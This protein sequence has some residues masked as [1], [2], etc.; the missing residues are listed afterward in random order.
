YCDCRVDKFGFADGWNYNE[1]WIDVIVVLDTSEA[2]GS[3]A[4]EDTAAL[5]ESLISD[6]ADDL[7]ITNTYLP[8][9]TRVG[10]LYNLNMTKADKVHGKVA[11]KK[12]VKEM[13]I[14]AGFVAAL[15]MFDDGLNAKP[16][17]ANTRQV[18]YYMT[19]SD[20]LKEGEAEMQGLK[21]LASPG[22]YF[23]SENYML[24]LQ[25]FCKANCFCPHGRLAYGGS[26]PAI[27]ASGGCY[28]ASTSGIPFNNAKSTCSNEGGLLA[29]I[30]DDQK[31]Q[32]VNKLSVMAH[33]KSD[34]FWIGYEKSDAGAWQWEDNSDD[35][36]TNWG[37]DEP[38]TNAVA[39]CGY[40]DSTSA[41]LAWGAGN[42]KVGFPYSCQYT[43]CSVGYKDC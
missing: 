9:Y 41:S 22:Y 40:V 30:H 34:Y 35:P 3:D 7:L 26:D 24:A 25:S 13:D 16:D 33:A 28:H 39:K 15:N 17:R 38:S 5:V 10:V 37:L 31:G 1:I 36:Y 43:P 2:M 18:V 32:F 20:F 6:G 42:C 8:F 14:L 21:N 29:T 12:G 23:S 4:L 11:I 27:Q 19:D